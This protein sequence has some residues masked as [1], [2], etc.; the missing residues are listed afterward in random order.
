MLMRVV[1]LSRRDAFW[2]DSAH[3]VGSV[4]DVD[5]KDVIRWEDEWV[6]VMKGKLVHGASPMTG[7]LMAGGVCLHEAKL[8]KVSLS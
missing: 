2:S 6:G 8:E 7:I 5:D 1:S 3:V 4:I